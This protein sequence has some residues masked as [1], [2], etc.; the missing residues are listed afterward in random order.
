M[1]GIAGILR[2]DLLPTQGERQLTTMLRA[3]KHRGPDDEGLWQNENGTVRFAHARLSILDLSPAGHQPMSSADGRF[4]ITFN[5]EIYNFLELRAALENDGVR[6]QTRTDTEVIL[7][8]YQTHGIDC[9]RHL[10]GMFAFAIWDERE[11]SCFLARGPFGIKP[12]YFVRQSGSFAF[13][14]EMQALQ[15]AGLTGKALDP[16]AVAAYFASGS[17]PEPLTL[18]KDV[19]LL[20]AGHSLV[21]KDGAITGARFWS[22]EFPTDIQPPRNAAAFTRTALLDSVEHHFVSDV[23]V[24]IFLSGGIDSTALLALSRTLGKTD[25]QTYSIGVNN[26]SLD[27]SSIARRTA[28]HFGAQHHELQLNDASGLETFGSFLESIDQ[29]TIDGLNTFTVSR[30]ARQHGAKVVLSGLGG[31]EIFGGYGT[32]QRVPFLWRCS[33][34]LRAIPGGKAIFKTMLATGRLSSRLQRLAPLTEGP[35]TL[36]DAYRIFR[37]INSR[38]DATKLA[39]HFT[40]ASADETKR[41]WPESAAENMLDAMSELELAGYMRNQL[42]KDSDVMSMAHGLELR[43]PFVDS[44]LFAAV[45]RIPASVRLRKGKQLLLD[46]VPEIPQWVRSQPKRGFLFPYAQWLGSPQWKNLFA[47][48]L[49]NIPVATPAWYQRWSVFVFEHWRQKHGIDAG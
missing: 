42:L 27:E 29:P 3:L 38:S 49:K 10:R 17:V 1:C 45:A 37:G 9:V 14:S 32:F 28:A 13:A 12:L 39:M 6:F 34:L 46:A 23:P 33:R 24:G 48:A 22:I 15:A 5:G 2:A 7:Q 30:F 40:E 18:L 35:L 25:L 21:W 47:D 44:A 8:L 26:A 11:R 16:A 19:S 43:V 31:D 36:G 20:E 41:S 4:T